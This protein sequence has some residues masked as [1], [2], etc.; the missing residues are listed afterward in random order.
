MPSIRL[1]ECIQGQRLSGE[2]RELRESSS[3]FGEWRDEC[4]TIEKMVEVPRNS[5]GGRVRLDKATLDA[6]MVVL[7]PEQSMEHI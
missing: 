3:Q 4:R 5:T 2:P 6:I 1:F 7:L